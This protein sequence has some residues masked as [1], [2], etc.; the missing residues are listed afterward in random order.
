MVKIVQMGRPKAKL[1]VSDQQRKQLNAIVRRTSSSQSHV[2]RARIVL[3]CARGFDN[4]EVAE[5]LGTTGQTVGKWRRRFVADGLEGL[6][7]A[8]RLGAPR[9]VGDEL[10]ATAIRKTLDESPRNATHWSTL[11]GERALCFAIERGSDLEG[12][13]LDSTFTSRLRS[14]RG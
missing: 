10:V 12:G 13:T 4:E 14:R 11:D 6:F 7:D 2:M 3:E 8:P 1:E 9:S 5:Q